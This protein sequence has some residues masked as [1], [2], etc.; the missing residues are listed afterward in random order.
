MKRFSKFLAVVALLGLFS[1]CAEKYTELYNLTPDEWYAQ[2]IADITILT[3]TLKDTA[4][5][6]QKQSLLS[7]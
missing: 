5:T 3:S 6:A 2:V 1:G 7:I 4:I